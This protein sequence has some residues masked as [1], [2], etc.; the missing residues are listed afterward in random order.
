MAYVVGLTGGIGSGKS[1]VAEYFR[2]FGAPIIDADV[3]ARE[4]V[5]PG[6][7]AFEAIVHHFGPSILA[8][9]GTLNRHLLREIVF[10]HLEEKA[11]L[12]SLLHPLIFHVFRQEISKVTYPYCIV[13]VPLLT[14]HYELYKNDFDHIIVID[15]TEA[16][17]LA[18]AA[19][20]DHCSESLI[21]KVILTQASRDERLNIANTVLSN[22]SNFETLKNKVKDLHHM[23]FTQSSI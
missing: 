22:K 6:K 8:E 19:K 16:H 1:T 11:W 20:R 13:V 21:K 3:L 4:L 17:Q 7:P 14:E 5:M 9:D 12:E 2:E 18:W 15:T 10:N 23:F